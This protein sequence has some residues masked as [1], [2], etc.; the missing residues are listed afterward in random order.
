MRLPESLSAS[1]LY[2]NLSY[3]NYHN[4]IQQA[5][6]GKLDILYLT[7]EKFLSENIYNLSNISLICIDESHCI[8]KYSKSSRLSYMLIK[9]IIKKIK[10][11]A[12]INDVV[13]WKSA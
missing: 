6:T 11:F 10:I 8:S 1:A 13:I 9:M 7:P 4:I 3:S 12:K 5:K 2:S